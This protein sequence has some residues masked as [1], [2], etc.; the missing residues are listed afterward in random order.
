M[1]VWRQLAIL[2]VTI[3]TKRSEV[4]GTRVMEEES[5]LNKDIPIHVSIQ[6]KMRIVASLL[7]TFD[8]KR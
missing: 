7:K 4:K 6:T 2:A 1:T 3:S 5:G 8:G